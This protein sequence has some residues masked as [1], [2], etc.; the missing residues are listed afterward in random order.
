MT[1]MEPLDDRGTGPV[2]GSSPDNLPA[3]PAAAEAMGQARAYWTTDPRPDLRADSD[4]WR[5]LLALAYDLDGDAPQGVFGV[6]HGLRCCGL[7][8][9]VERGRARLAAGEMGEGEYRAL[10]DEWLV[11]HEARVRGLLAALRDRSGR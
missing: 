5:R 4:S 10:R 2:S 9:T 11:P 8:L 3:S 1:A 6:L 7:Q